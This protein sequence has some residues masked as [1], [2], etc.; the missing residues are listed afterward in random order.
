L[1]KSKDKWYIKKL[2]KGAVHFGKG[3]KLEATDLL[4]K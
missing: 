4:L 1:D 2:G 3:K